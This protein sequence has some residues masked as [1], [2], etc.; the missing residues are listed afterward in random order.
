MNEHEQVVRQGIPPDKLLVTIISPSIIPRY[1]PGFRL[2]RYRRDSKDSQE[3]F[4]ISP[5]TKALTMN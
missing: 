2:V 1:Q 3:P 5:P 4:L